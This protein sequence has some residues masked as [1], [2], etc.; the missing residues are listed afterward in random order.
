MDQ[1]RFEHGEGLQGIF[2]GSQ[3]PEMPMASLPPRSITETMAQPTP[4]IAPI[5]PPT[6]AHEPTFEP[7]P[8]PSVPPTG[9][10]EVTRHRVPPPER[11][12]GMKLAV[13]AA[14]VL[15]V[16]ALFTGLT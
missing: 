3:P 11:N 16:A 6:T 8:E 10:P 15:A 4:R 12:A 9:R 14:G 2:Q 1:A 13:G 7:S 5:K